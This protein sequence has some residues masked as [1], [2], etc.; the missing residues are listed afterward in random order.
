MLTG[1]AE[2]FVIRHGQASFG[3][4]NYDQLSPLGW[5]QARWLGQWLAEQG[6]QFDRLVRGSLQRHRQTLEGIL[7]GFAAAPQGCGLDHL[8]TLELPG[9]NEFD[10]EKILSAHR[11]ESG[12]SVDLQQLARADRREYFR[13][14]REALY[15][16]SRGALLP[17]DYA[18]HSEFKAAVLEAVQQAC[19][20]G[21]ERVLLVSSGGPI[22][23]L[24]GHVLRVPAEVTVDLNLQT[25]NAS[26]TQFAYSAQSSPAS[27]TLISFNNIAHLQHPD[28]RAAVTYA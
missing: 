14:L 1:M 9:L 21:A 25:R 4:A 18:S 7:E 19:Q 6:W 17:S 22:A 12:N 27:L 3:E 10:S 13:R 2:L 16:W 23:N 26:L 24:V 20:P 8:P 5:Q 11:P 15:D 28:R